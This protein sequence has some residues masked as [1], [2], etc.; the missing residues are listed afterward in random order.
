MFF[1]AI[2]ETPALL[3]S[4]LLII[5]EVSIYC[6]FTIVNKFLI[7]PFLKSLEKDPTK[8]SNYRPVALLNVLRKMYEHIIGERLKAFLEKNEYLSSVQAAYRKGRST[9]DNI[10]ILQELFHMYRYNKGVKR[11]ISGK[12]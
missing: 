11:K 2:T 10:L 4:T 12:K 7:R 1:E 9:A 6:L 3:V 5:L 8:P